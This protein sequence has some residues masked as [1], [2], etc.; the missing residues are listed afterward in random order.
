MNYL[1][2]KSCYSPACNN[3][4]AA[5]CG[6][7]TSTAELVSSEQKSSPLPLST[8][9]PCK[10]L[11]TIPGGQPSSNSWLKTTVKGGTTLKDVV[12]KILA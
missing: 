2:A 8:A 11:S 10:P 4:S 7:K 3:T 5:L 6:A 9:M 12:M 1:G